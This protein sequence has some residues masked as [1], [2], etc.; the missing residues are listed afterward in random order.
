MKTP[1]LIALG[2]FMGYYVYWNVPLAYYAILLYFCLAI[3]V[4]IRQVVRAY[5]AFSDK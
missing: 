5:T 4:F 2:F 1:L 3:F